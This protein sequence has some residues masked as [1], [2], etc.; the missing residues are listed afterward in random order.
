MNTK[1]N[2]VKLV[3]MSILTAILTMSMTACSSDDDIMSQDY[4]KGST[5]K[6][7]PITRPPHATTDW[8]S[9]A[10]AQAG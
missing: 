4:S 1:K 8:C 9:G 6:D 3:L 7:A 5:H 10:T 2:L